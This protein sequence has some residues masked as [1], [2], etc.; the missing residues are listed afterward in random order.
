MLLI[1]L[2]VPVFVAGTV[3][4]APAAVGIPTKT[5]EERATTVCGLW[6]TITTGTYS[7]S[8][9]LWGTGSATSG[10]QC[11]TFNSLSGSSVSWSTSW[12]WAGGSNSVKSY[13]NV[14][15][16]MSSGRQVS[17]ISSI[18]S[19][20]KYTY[21]GSNI[22]AD[23]AY[24]IFTSGSSSGSHE[25]E[26]MIWLAALGGAGPIS[27]SGSPV[28]TT[29]IAGTSWKLYSGMNGSFKVFS[30]V[31][32]SQVTDFSADLKLFL[33]YLANNQGFQTSQYITYIGAGTEPFT[34]SN[35]KLS[36]SA[37]SVAIK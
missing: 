8:Q 24:D 10:S 18:P 7:I 9:N 37:Y 3:L 12:T 22:V 5:I 31:A 20:W 16:Q 21:T 28:T 23:A 6:D 34:G 29:T 2:L 4:R 27:S 13:S 11:L 25:Y 1:N 17:S 15:L 30:F 35:A 36:T 14:N 26:I 19:V 33:T 32:S